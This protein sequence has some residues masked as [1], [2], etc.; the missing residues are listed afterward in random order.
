MFLGV[1]PENQRYVYVKTCTVRYIK[2]KERN[3]MYEEVTNSQHCQ[4]VKGD[5]LE[6]KLQILT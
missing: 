3:L 4:T 2:D 5:T 1:V 6:S